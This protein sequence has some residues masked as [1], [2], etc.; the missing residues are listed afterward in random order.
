M[1]NYMVGNQITGRHKV[2]T[3]VI[4]I[5]SSW[6]HP[7]H[8]TQGPQVSFLHWGTQGACPHHPT[9]TAFTKKCY[10]IHEMT[11]ILLFH[12]ALS[13]LKLQTLRKNVFFFFFFP[14]P[15]TK[16]LP[17]WQV[18][19]FMGVSVCV[20]LKHLKLIH[21]V[22]APLDFTCLVYVPFMQRFL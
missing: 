2:F 18:L 22:P 11:W 3:G 10:L 12:Y 1:V 15:F 5:N 13:L 8:I 19:R 17:L 7:R 4:F 21:W 20:Y 6:K 9:K 16:M 14:P